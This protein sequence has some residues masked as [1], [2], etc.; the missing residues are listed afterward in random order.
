MDNTKVR[1][2]SL[3]KVDQVIKIL[4]GSISVPAVDAFGSTS[5]LTSLAPTFYQGIYTVDNS[6]DYGLIG[7]EQDFGTS[8]SIV[9][10]DAYSSNNNFYIQAFSDGLAD[11]TVKFQVGLI[12][13]PTQGLVDIS[14]VGSK[15]YLDT[16]TNNYQKVAFEKTVTVNIATGNA[17]TGGVTTLPVVHNLGYIPTVRG[18]ISNGTRISDVMAK[19]SISLLDSINIS[20]SVRVD[21][22]SVY[23]DFNNFTA[24]PHTY[25]L[26]YRIYYDPA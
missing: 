10:V 23:F 22:S 12:A 18:Y 16:F 17:S 24:N 3:N 6:S 8:P 21:T 15:T 25:T 1:F 11:Y 20:T 5:L 4:S 13:T 7:F 14:T 19:S 26:T 9:E 2:N